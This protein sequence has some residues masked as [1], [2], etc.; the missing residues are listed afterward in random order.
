MNR[1]NVKRKNDRTIAKK[2]NGFSL[3]E[4]EKAKITVVESASLNIYIDKRRK[5]CHKLNVENLKKMKKN[6]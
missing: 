3:A 2:G 1:P 5:S 4:L 6:K